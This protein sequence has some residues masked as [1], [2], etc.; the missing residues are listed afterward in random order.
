M[1]RNPGVTDEEI[2]RM[3]KS[4]IPYKEMEPIVG[5]SSRS[6]RNVMYKH[7]VQMNREQSSG[8][9][10]KHKVN[11]NFFK[12]WSNE[13]AWVLGLFVT[14]GTVN[15]SVHSIVF[16]QKDERILR[17]IAAYM[18]ADYVLAP[19]GPTRHTPSLI[20]NSKVI[21]ND[22]A[23]MGIGA[24]KSLTVPFP[25]V[26]EEFLPSFIRG[27]I[28]GD[29][30]VSRDGYN[31]NI[32]SGSI[33]FAEG[34]LSVF[35]KWGLKSKITTFKG[36]KDNQ[37]Y[38]IWITGKTEVLK[39]SEIIYQDATSDD[40]VI[41]KRVYMS[42]HSV[43]PYKSEIPFYEKISSRVQFRTNISKYIL[44]SLRIAA[45]EHHTTI[46]NLF[47][48]GLKNLLGTPVLEINKLSRPVDRVQFKTTYDRE[49][50]MKVREFAKQNDLYINDVIEMSVDYIDSS[51]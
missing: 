23:E 4:G 13:M 37:I 51:Y 47:E 31:L 1:P 11:E 44:E 28:D 30:W 22:L 29:G 7:G 39:L 2:I 36:T 18:E 50:L 41:K 8:Q 16:S 32:T 5:L 27:V 48:K 19:D 49:L 9:P 21:K 40:Y 3:Y 20:I 42:Q 10:R 43:R 25:N 45:I 26:P 33:Q 24:R 15:S 17:L 38:R 34:L 46:N 12:V 35:L 14:D 6:I